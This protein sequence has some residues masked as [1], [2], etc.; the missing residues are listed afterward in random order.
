MD[1]LRDVL[2]LDPVMLCTQGKHCSLVSD[3]TQISYDRRFFF[4]IAML[5][6]SLPFLA[7]S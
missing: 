5:M 2:M 4:L 1:S 6:A 7:V 3:P